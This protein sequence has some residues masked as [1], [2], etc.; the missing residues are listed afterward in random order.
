MKWRRLASAAAPAALLIVTTAVC[1][2]VGELVVRFIDGYRLSTLRLIPHATT[3]AGL[4]AERRNVAQQ[5]LSSVPLA[6]G[7]QTSWFELAPEPLPGRDRPDPVLSE[8]VRRSAST[9]VGNEIVR[10]YNWEFVRGQ[11]CSDDY[12]RELP[13]FGFVYDPQE[14]AAH[15]R[16]RYPPNVVLPTGLVINQ[17]GWRGPSIDFPKAP[18]TIRVAFV[19][20][21]TTINHH[22]YPF[23]YPELVGFWL[24]LWLKAQG[25]DVKV[26][27]IN[28]A[29]EGINSN[30]IAAVVRDEL[31]P[32]SPDLVV[33]YEGSN[34]FAPRDIIRLPS[35]WKLRRS[36]EKRLAT[37]QSHSAVA[38]R[39]TE[40]ARLGRNFGARSAAG[41]EP[42]K[43]D[44]EVAWPSDVDETDPP[45]EHGNLPSNLSVILDDLQRIHSHLQKAGAELVLSSFFWLVYDG[46]QLDPQRDRFFY[47]YLNVRY[48]P[49]RYQEMERLAAFQNRVFRK[50]AA[51]KGIEF[52]EIAERMPR[53]VNLFFDPIH[54][55]YDGVRL[56]AWIAA[57]Q[58]APVLQRRIDEGRLPSSVHNELASHPAFAKGVRTI[59]IDCRQGSKGADAD[60]AKPF[61]AGL[62]IP[63]TGR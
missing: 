30:D 15:P 63:P 54:A 5:Y 57:Q 20:A 43:L 36:T 39:L 51:T 8:A 41:A 55:T 31:L 60:S 37:L 29:R 10:A 23:S 12:F 28:A 48:D 22:S 14:G 26:E 53:D 9:K 44:Y 52:L 46:M 34:Q 3:A 62:A 58:L 45:L 56:H 24:N 42:P 49:Y 7:M 25:H 59:T 1:L 16:Y 40:L 4:A 6:P 2:L 19:G 27:S 61:A 47:E 17:F 35:L 13:G 32:M 18:R 11:L 50:F 33:Y 38:R 21:S